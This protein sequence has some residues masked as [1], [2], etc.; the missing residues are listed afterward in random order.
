[1]RAVPLQGTERPAVGNV[2][3]I[4]VKAGSLVAR[5][6]LGEVAIVIDQLAIQGG[7][8]QP[9]LADLKDAT[10]TTLCSDRVAT[11]HDFAVALADLA[12]ASGAVVD[13]RAPRGAG[14]HLPAG[15]GVRTGRQSATV[16]ARIDPDFVGRVRLTAAAGGVE[17]ALDVDVRPSGECPRR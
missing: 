3:L 11:Y 17:R 13:L 10:G 5:T 4:L 15:V 6:D 12:T 1:M 14:L 9:P 16:T 2:R 7:V 8:V